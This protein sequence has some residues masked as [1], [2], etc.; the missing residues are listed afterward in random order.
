MIPLGGPGV[1]AAGGFGPASATGGAP[2]IVGGPRGVV[3]SR[4]VTVADTSFATTTVT[5]P[6]SSQ[7]LYILLSVTAGAAVI[8]VQGNGPETYATTVSTTLPST[9]QLPGFPQ[10]TTVGVQSE[11]LAAATL[12]GVVFYV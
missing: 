4:L 5:L 10:T 6:R 9:L 7:P 12:T 11:I 1:P 8:Q 2:A 3:F